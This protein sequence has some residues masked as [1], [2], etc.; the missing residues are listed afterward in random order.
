MR[1]DHQDR[2]LLVPAPILIALVVPSP[3]SVPTAYGFNLLITTA[4]LLGNAVF[5]SS[6]PEA[7][8]CSATIDAPGTTL[9]DDRLLALLLAT[10]KTGLSIHRPAL[11]VTLLH[12][13]PLAVFAVPGQPLPS[14]AIMGLGVGTF[15]AAKRHYTRRHPARYKGSC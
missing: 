12:S 6:I 3:V 5:Q 13:C 14:F 15:S 11:A 2:V 1:L 7:A 10:S 9:L 8:R 4:A